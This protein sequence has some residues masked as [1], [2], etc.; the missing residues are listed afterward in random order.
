MDEE[1]P[2]R[3]DVAGP[4][5]GVHGTPLT[6]WTQLV[7]P[8]ATVLECS[9]EGTSRRLTNKRCGTLAPLP[10]DLTGP[11]P[12]FTFALRQLYA[13]LGFS[14]NELERRLPASRSSLS[15]YL[16]GQGLPDEKLLVQW[17]RLSPAG[18]E[19]L[20][21]LLQLVRRAGDEAHLPEQP[22]PVIAEDEQPGS[23]LPSKK[24]S[25]LKGLHWVLIA[26]SVVA[27]AITAAVVTYLLSRS[28]TTPPGSSAAADPVPVTVYNVEAGCRAN[29]SRPRNCGLGLARDPYSMYR[30]ENVADFVWHGDVL[31]AE[32]RIADG[33][34]ITD[35]NGQHSSIWYRVSHPRHPLWLPG[36]RV[37][38]EPA[39][40]PPLC[41]R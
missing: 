33:V 22:S 19:H 15:R 1:R 9:M 27:A 25:R 29:T 21:D 10:D 24:E 2:T 32:C 35:E 6:G 16:R 4:S 34:S 13:A 38:P 3:H 18:E 39:V 11:A 31:Q 20:T 5:T 30:P 41:S 28:S 36:I 14:L 37:R 17:C 23:A 40:P 26:V 8:I 7:P 12:E